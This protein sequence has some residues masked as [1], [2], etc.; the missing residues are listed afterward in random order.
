MSILGVLHKFFPYLFLGLLAFSVMLLVS[1]AAAPI[2]GRDQGVYLYIADQILEGQI[3]YR[4]LWDHKGPLV[5]YLNALGLLLSGSMWGVWLVQVAFV[6]GAGFLCFAAVEKMFQFIPAL[7][8]SAVWLMSL[9]NVIDAGNHVEMYSLLFEFFVLFIYVHLEKKEKLVVWDF[10]IGVSAALSFLLRP[11]NI[12]LSMTI[13]LW[14]VVQAVFNKEIRKRNIL[15]LVSICSGAL[16]VLAA[17]V[18]Y[19]ALNDALHDM[20]DALIFYNVQYSNSPLLDRWELLVKGLSL[21]PGLF[22]SGIIAWV[23]GLVIIMF[24]IEQPQPFM[25]FLPIILLSFPVSLLLTFVSGRRHIHYYLLWLPSLALLLGLIAYKLQQVVSNQIELK[26]GY[27]SNFWAKGL[28]A[29]VVGVLFAFSAGQFVTGFNILGESGGLKAQQA[30]A[31]E[32]DSNSTYLNYVLENT[33]PD[34]YV[35]VWGNEVWV[36]YLTDRAAPSRFIYQ[37]PLINPDYVSS[38]MAETF[39]NDIIQKKPIILDNTD[40]NRQVPII[41]SSAWGNYPKMQEVIRYIRENYQIV[42]YIG[43]DDWRVWVHK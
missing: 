29:I 25:K 23:I 35:L 11:N 5:Y 40:S 4:D 27:T 17:V 39:L 24:R 16:L 12:V 33:Q 42:D 38:E 32:L 21:I 9:S 36:N 1:P 30:A 20:L 6:V 34:E 7:I 13:G 43:V 8:A 15:R 3:P 10:F 18:L 37:Y 22:I 2:P 19:F 41:S 14:L 28:A 26:A 31:F